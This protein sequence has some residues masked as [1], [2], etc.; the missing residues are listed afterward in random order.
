MPNRRDDIEPQPVTDDDLFLMFREGQAEAFD[1]LFDRHYVS[2]HNFARVMLR[3]PGAAEEVLQETFLAVARATGKYEPRG[4]FRSW[5]LRITRNRCLNRLEAQRTRQVVLAQVPSG[6]LQHPSPEPE[7]MQKAMAV[8]QMELVR[9]AMLALPDR[10]REA[11]ALYAC[12]QMTYQQIADV[13]EMPINTVKTLIH[14]ARARLAETLDCGGQGS[15]GMNHGGTETQRDT[16]AR[17]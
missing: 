16:R 1:V 7:P 17:Q 14:R 12:E 8:E 2:V 9:K 10:Q 11:I 13:L 5:L 6:L 3:E 15:C 4:Q